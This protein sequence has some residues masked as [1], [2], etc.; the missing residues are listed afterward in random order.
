MTTG[1]EPPMSELVEHLFRSHA[2]QMFATLTHVFR[3]ERLER[4]EAR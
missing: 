4:A 3:L 2:E 1:G